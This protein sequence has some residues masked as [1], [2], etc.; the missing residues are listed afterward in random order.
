MVRD[1]NVRMHSVAVLSVVLLAIGCRSTEPVD[2]VGPQQMAPLRVW[3]RTEHQ[4]SD[5]TR[6]AIVEVDGVEY[7][8]V[9]KPTHRGGTAIIRHDRPKATRAKK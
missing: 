4:L 9:Y 5:S 8:V 1:I 6:I 7:V 3:L 2:R